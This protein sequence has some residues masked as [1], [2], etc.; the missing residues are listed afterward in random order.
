MI[1]SKRLDP[2]AR[3]GAMFD[4]L[5]VVLVQQGDSRAMERLHARWTPRLARAALRYTGDAELARDLVQE[6]W[7][8]IWKGLRRLKS[9][10]RFRSYIFAVLHRRG[11]DHLR[12]AIND[13]KTRA[14][15]GLDE[16]PDQPVDPAQG[17][18]LAIKQAFAAL[19]PDQRLAAHLYFVE[20][21]TM[22][23][24]AEVQDIAEGTAKSRLFHARR[25][26]KAAL[27]DTK[28]ESNQGEHL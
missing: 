2:Q 15:C 18:G 13:R 9:P 16:M 22:Q 20:G 24:I 3:S 28:P 19:P 17:E 23:D 26:L 21:L 1:Q 11:S 27:S 8:G 6:C 4:E 25:K 14:D 5:L 10:A 12:S 7:I